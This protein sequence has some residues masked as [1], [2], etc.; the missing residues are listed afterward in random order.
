MARDVFTDAKVAE[1]YNDKFVNVQVDMEKGEGIDLAK[2]Y[3][4]RAYPTL[5]F[6]DGNGEIVHRAVGYH[7][8]DDFMALGA[9]ALDPSKRLSALDKR[10]ESGDR[11]PEF[12]YEYTFARYDAHDGSHG[13]IAEAYLAT[14]DDWSKEEN[15]GFIM[16]FTDNTETKLFDYLVENRQAF[17][18]NF[19][20][21]MTMNKIRSLL[22]G[23]AY[24][25][26]ISNEELLAEVDALIIKAFPEE[27]AELKS[28]YRIFVHRIRGNQEDFVDAVIKHYNNYPSDDWQELNEIAWMFFESVEGKKELK[29]AVKWAER[30][31]ELEKNYYNTDTVASLYYKLGKKGKARKWANIAIEQAKKEGEDPGTTEELLKKIEEL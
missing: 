31:V 20:K 8:S 5:L 19:G 11:D 21:E 12:L 18:D 26:E 15:L 10:Y 27:A 17:E 29:Q 13:P 28:D 9:T 4:V 1:F 3:E 24:D 22:Y 23:K 16:T 25:Q 30:S 7:T 2:K 14:Q 6:I